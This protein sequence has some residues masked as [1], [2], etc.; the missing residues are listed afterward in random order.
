MD[1]FQPANENGGILQ[2]GNAYDSIALFTV[3]GAT[4]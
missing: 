3:N 4:K 2:N 1:D